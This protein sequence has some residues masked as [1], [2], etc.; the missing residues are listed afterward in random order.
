MRPRYPQ[1]V[2]FRAVFFDVGET[3]VHVDPSFV[4]LFVPVLAGA[5]HR[6]AEEEVRVASAQV[7]A[8][9]SHP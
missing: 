1:G 8:W 2:R 6:R 3:L 5:G 7:Y 9:F 4:D